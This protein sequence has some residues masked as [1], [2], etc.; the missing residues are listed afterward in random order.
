MPCVVH[1][2]KMRLRIDV[3]WV[4]LRISYIS[5]DIQ[6]SSLECHRLPTILNSTIQQKIFDDLGLSDSSWLHSLMSNATI[7][8]WC[9]DFLLKKKNFKNILSVRMD[10]RVIHINF[11]STHRWWNICV[12]RFVPQLNSRLVDRQHLSTRADAWEFF[13]CC[14]WL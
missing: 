1:S 8:G 6:R 9:G 5:L 11:C 3:T 13:K 4:F 14:Y 2:L 12:G 10:V 7:N